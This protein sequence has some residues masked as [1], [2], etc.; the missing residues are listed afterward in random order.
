MDKIKI[1]LHILHSFLSIVYLIWMKAFNLV[2][3]LLDTSI[4]QLRKYICNI[5]ASL[6]LPFDKS[7]E[8]EDEQ[9]ELEYEGEENYA[10]ISQHVLFYLEKPRDI[11]I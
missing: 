2:C 3:S 11:C 6:V 1:Y 9:S 5:L 7:M 8:E 10:Q 4:F